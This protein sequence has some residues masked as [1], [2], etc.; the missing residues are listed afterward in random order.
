MCRLFVYIGCL[1]VLTACVKQVDEPVFVDKLVMH[2]SLTNDPHSHS[3]SVSLL[4]P[5]G[6]QD[7][8]P[9]DELSEVFIESE[10][11]TL[12]LNSI[13]RLNYT[14]QR[15]IMAQPHTSYRLRFHWQARPYASTF[16]T[17]PLAPRIRSHR[18]TR[19]PC[20]GSFLGLDECYLIFVLFKDPIT[21]NYYRWKLADLHPGLVTLLDFPFSSDVLL[22]SDDL[23]NAELVE[24]RIGPLK[25]TSGTEIELQLCSMNQTQYEYLRAIFLQQEN[26][27]KQPL[28]PITP[29]ANIYALDGEDSQVFGYFSLMH[30]QKIR[31]LVP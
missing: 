9:L 29:A 1:S 23:F 3:T 7:S 28:I 17:L 27:E 26:T 31:I 19:V 30:V 20:S 24:R 8:R 2:S 16:D 15:E 22:F 6:A 21:D 14:L 25:L 11:D 5:L 4:T 13:N 10:T 18:I 12:Y